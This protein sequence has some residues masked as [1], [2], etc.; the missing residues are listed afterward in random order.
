MCGIVGYFSWSGRPLEPG[1]IEAMVGALAHRGP[2]D[3]GVWTAGDASAALGQS[4][5]SIIDLSA[6]GHQPMAN[7]DGSLWLVF[8]GEI[9]N[10]EELRADLRVRGHVFRSA[11]DS[12][13]IL[14]QYEEDGDA[15][16]ER[17]NGMFAFALFDVRRRRL[18]LGRDRAGEKPLFFATGPDHVVFASE[19]KAILASGLVQPAI[20][21][22]ALRTCMVY[23]AMAAPMTVFA[24]VRQLLP[25]HV[26]S[27]D[28]AGFGT[29][30]PYWNLLERVANARALPTCDQA[31]LEG[32]ADHLDRSVRLRMRSDA[33]FG[34]F[35]SGGLDSSAIVKVMRQ[36]TDQ[37]LRTYAFAFREG[38]FDESGMA[39]E[40]A[41]IL[42]TD[43]NT[44]EAPMAN[45][46]QLLEKAVYHG[47][48]YTPNPCFIPVYLLCQGA[49][50]H[51][52]MVLSGDG[53]DELL[54]G[55]ETYQATA[56]ARLYGR[57][58]A[59]LRRL[60]AAAIRRLPPSEAKVPLEDKLKRFV[61]GAEAPG[62]NSHALWRHIFQPD[63]VD[64]VLA[65]PFAGA[66]GDP[67]RLYNDRIQA[68]AALP[69]VSRLLFADFS[70]YMPNDALVKMDRMGMANGLE[71][72]APF[73]DHHLV[74]FC[75][76]MPDRLKLR[77]W[78][79]KKHVLKRFLAGTIPDRLIT[80]KKA[81]FNVPVD[82][83]LRGPLRPML[84]DCL[85]AA[86]MR[87]LGIFRPEAVQSL[88][89]EHLSGRAN[90]GLKLWNLLSFTVWHRLFLKAAVG[91]SEM[92]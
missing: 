71:V 83:W 64:A 51:V 41:A 62:L 48:E 13:V 17:F 47:E 23:N 84:E 75:F 92:G 69:F 43:H 22:A 37:P 32:F 25:A 55:Y 49:A 14:H 91:G 8:N 30:R 54:A 77:R 24:G 78:T 26:V 58:P 86:D 36:T 10:F 89:T 76:A 44:I 31:W 85:S 67:T 28:R 4:R 61:Y 74:E 65:T 9:Y 39:K 90:H 72:R 15:C 11:S 80:R 34:A 7:E 12:E 66:G 29:P 88:L 50:R 68:G 60:A 42:G 82:A 3:S 73:L 6:A 40:V 16:L 81:G 87:R 52:K 63:Q 27:V 5:L 56:L 2:D 53:A 35:L 79:G 57:M 45:L 46:P 70:Y 20:D 59:P 1:R 18:L 33:P 38:S 21:A 19:I